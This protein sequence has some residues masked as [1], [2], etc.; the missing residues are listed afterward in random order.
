[1]YGFQSR[2][3]SA[4]SCRL[5]KHMNLTVYMMIVLIHMHMA[6]DFVWACVI[7]TRGYLRA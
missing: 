3:S 5:R 6:G 1:M 4:W 7:V 2:E